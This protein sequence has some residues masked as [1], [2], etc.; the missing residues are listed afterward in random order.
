MKNLFKILVL[1][2]II[3]TISIIINHRLTFNQ[4]LSIL[5]L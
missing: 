1:F 2:L 4:P 5:N 3:I